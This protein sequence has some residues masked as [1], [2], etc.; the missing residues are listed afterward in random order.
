M[1][2]FFTFKVL[3]PSVSAMFHNKFKAH[4]SQHLSEDKQ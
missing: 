2:F 1:N 3:F 4:T